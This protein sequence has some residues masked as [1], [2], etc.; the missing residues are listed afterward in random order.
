MRSLHKRLLALLIVGAGL[1]CAPAAR[2]DQLEA[3]GFHVGSQ[4]VTLTSPGFVLGPTVHAGAL[5]LN[6]PAG[7]IAYCID[8]FQTISLG[9]LYN[10]YTTSTLAADPHLTAT[11]KAEIAQ[12]FHGF[13]DTSLTSSVNSAAFQLALWEITFEQAG[14]PLNVDGASGSKGTTYATG[15]DAPGSVIAIADTWLGQLGSFSTDLD[16][17]TSYRSDSRQDLISYHGGRVPGPATLTMVL[18]GVGM[19]TLIARRRAPDP[20]RAPG[21]REQFRR[22]LGIEPEAEKLQ[23]PEACSP[24]RVMQVLTP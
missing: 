19:V 6:P 22:G 10:S 13:Y 5:D 24:R 7:V 9:T 14:N 23:R 18:A 11:R 15:S 12:L 1:A 4:N 17:F 2:A 8:I 3:T 16:G 20:P 21:V